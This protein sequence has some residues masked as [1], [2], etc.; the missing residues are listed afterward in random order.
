[1]RL[2]VAILLNDSVKSKLTKL[3]RRLS[4][5]CEGV[6]WT[7]PEQLHITAKFIGEV[8]DR[9]VPEVCS[10]VSRA[11]LRSRPFEMSISGCG[12]FPE[13]GPIRIVW[14]RIKEDSGALHDCIDALESELESIGYPRE[15]RP[16]S[17]HITLGRI[18][19][20]RSNDLYR[21]LVDKKELESKPQSVSSM[22]LISS[23]L[24]SWGPTYAV[25]S[26]AKFGGTNSS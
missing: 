4:G 19:D 23:K 26:T 9:D 11:A 2:F 8:K 15:R 14:A 20:D 17:A 21:S 5:Q 3:Q 12:C 6:R 16:F 13:H 22:V 18:R 1:M 10:A 24:A 7:K 25:A